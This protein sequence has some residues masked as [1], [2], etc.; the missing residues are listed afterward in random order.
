M[1]TRIIYWFVLLLCISCK[2]E[3]ELTF[4]PIS[5][6]QNN[7]GECP[8]VAITIPNAIENNTIDD[9]VNTA[10]REEVIS[11]INFDEETQIAGIPDAIK[12]FGFG[13]QELKEKFAEETTPWEAKITGVVIYE[14]KTI[15]T[16]RLDSY[17]F[18]GGAH[19]YSTTRFL[20]FDKT[21]A[22]ELKNGDLFKNKLDFE[23]FAET[24][25]R[26]QENIPTEQSINTT[27]F[28]F[29]TDTFH[30]PENIGYTKEGLQLFYEPYE[31]A[32]YADGPIL[33]TLPYS[34]LTKY[35]QFSPKP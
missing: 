33:L 21:K 11:L 18:T 10:L 30:L 20:N 19:G 32:P 15:L 31:I 29:E 1:N 2:N 27:G 4:E 8:V 35:L 9:V 7:C 24:K 25:F 6:T 28:M 14:D 3:N 34:E 22:K 13:Y 5:F 16:I 23:E 17:L 12:S 26:L